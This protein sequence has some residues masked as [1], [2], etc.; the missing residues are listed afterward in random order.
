MNSVTK[1]II[2]TASGLTP[3][4]M[5]TYTVSVYDFADAQYQDVYTGRCVADAYG[6]AVLRIDGVCRDF[7]YAWPK[8][9]S[10]NTQGMKPILTYFGNTSQPIDTGGI[11]YASDAQVTVYDDS[12]QQ[13]YLQ[14]NITLWAGSLA[15]WQQGDIYYT[16][17]T[18]YNAA[19]IGNSVVPRIPAINTANYWLG[20]TLTAFFDANFAPTSFRLSASLLYVDQPIGG[21][22]THVCHWLLSELLGQMIEDVIDG[23]N[24]EDDPNAIVLDGGD[25][26]DVASDEYDGGDAEP[27]SITLEGQD[28]I[29]TIGGDTQTMATFDACASPY[30]VAWRLPSGGWMSWGFDG[31]VTYGSANTITK[32][33]DLA[34]ID[35]TIGID[36]Q[37]IFSLRSGFVTRE[38]YNMLCTLKYAREAY[39]Y[40]VARDT[41]TWCN[42]DSRA[43]ET[44]GNMRWRNQ[45]FTLQLTQQQHVKL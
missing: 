37:A 43:L 39:V 9:W 38:Q 2:I 30:Y 18:W 26:D 16:Q 36:T 45:P 40:D 7:V 34:G 35:N 15:P 33:Q 12:D 10:Q 8:A 42:V 13:V 28:I 32:V 24:A 1:P 11:F 22:G 21:E 4:A 14:Q 23:G 44:A 31:N 41:G 29:L 20:L 5:N 19:F 17:G 6:N 25:A 27:Y 3:Y